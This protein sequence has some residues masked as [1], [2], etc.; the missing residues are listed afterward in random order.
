MLPLAKGFILIS[1]ILI[2]V[3]ATMQD[4]H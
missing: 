2:P 3:A 1:R 4:L